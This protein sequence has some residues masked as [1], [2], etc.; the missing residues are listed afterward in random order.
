M[1]GTIM[2]KIKVKD[3][4]T[5]CVNLSATF[6]SPQLAV[7]RT[8]DWNLCN[9]LILINFFQFLVRRPQ[10]AKPRCGLEKY[11]INHRLI[12][13]RRMQLSLYKY[14]GATPSLHPYDRRVRTKKRK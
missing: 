10:N 9:R 13:V 7:L 3:F 4:L 14:T 6:S 11:H 2:I 12:L 1:M 5:I 8:A